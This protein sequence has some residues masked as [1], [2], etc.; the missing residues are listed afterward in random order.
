MWLILVDVSCIGKHHSTK[1][2]AA[3]PSIITL[4]IFL[5]DTFPF[6]LLAV[7]V[8]IAVTFVLTWIL[9]FEDKILHGE[10]KQQNTE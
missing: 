7:A 8:T 6:T 4:P 10:E 5:G 1:N 9:G 3:S 2:K